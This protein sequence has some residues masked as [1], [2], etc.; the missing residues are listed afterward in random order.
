M[1]SSAPVANVMTCPSVPTRCMYS[2][3]LPA[4]SGWMVA[5]YWSPTLPIPGPLR[6]SSDASV[7]VMLS[8]G[9][10]VQV[11]VHASV[12]SAPS[13]STSVPVPFTDSCKLESWAIQWSKNDTG[14][15][16][17]RL[18]TCPGK[19]R[20]GSLTCGFAASRADRLT[21]NFSAMPLS[22]SPDWT[23]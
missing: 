2:S 14:F 15:G 13:P 9:F 4:A 12:L 3:W 21:P 6:P 20:L 10:F 19:I 11:T 23:T 22:V 18:R 7:I 1:L 17:G 16:P 5:M 8:L